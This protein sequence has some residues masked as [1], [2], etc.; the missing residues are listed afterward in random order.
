MSRLR[1][2]HVRRMMRMSEKSNHNYPSAYLTGPRCAPQTIPI[3]HAQREPPVNRSEMLV[4]QFYR[5]LAGWYLLRQAVATVT[6]WLFAWGTAV[7]VLRGAFSLSPLL[8]FL[9]VLGVPIAVALAAWLVQRKLP[10]RDVVRALLDGRG[11][12]GGLLMAG[13]ECDLGRWT[14][15]VPVKSSPRLTWNYRRPAALFTV[16]LGYLLLSFLLPIDRSALAGDARLDLARETDRLADQ[17]RVLKEEKIL[18]PERTEQLREKLEQVKSSSASKD[19]ARTLEA[20]DHLNDLLRQEAR[21]ASE[22]AGR[23]AN[24]LAQLETAADALQKAGSEL[25]EKNLTELMAELAAMT[26]QAAA[27]NDKLQEA[28]DGELADAVKQG[29]LSPEQLE[30]LSRRTE[31]C[32]EGIR[33]SAERLHKAKLIDFD[34]LE[35]CNGECKC[36]GKELAEYLK[37]CQG[38]KGLSESLLRMD[39]RGGVSDDPPGDTPIQFGDLSSEEGAKFREEALPPAA[40]QSLKDSQMT[41]LSATAPKRDP[42]TG[43]P[44]SG[45]LAGPSG[46]GSANTGQVLPQHKNAVDKY[47]DRGGK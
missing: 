3:H 44:V 30:K 40:I 27:E 38:K 8:H 31:G 29:K 21:K 18:D 33:K 10:H 6:V 9:G 19:P 24:A 43:K 22:L 5:R 16:S 20:L 34:Q 1:R 37:K 28:L 13:A 42:K 36:N 17:V 47:F 45:A 23:Q 46:G 15:T 35:E 39:G 25:G 41:G 11:E 2:L 12:C 26:K 32:K 14:A 7:V 4:D